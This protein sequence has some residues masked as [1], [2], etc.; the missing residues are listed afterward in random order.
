MVSI[1]TVCFLT[2]III[3]KRYIVKFLEKSEMSH[4]MSEIFNLDYIKKCFI[5]D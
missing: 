1:K 3:I 4:K 5:N 2:I